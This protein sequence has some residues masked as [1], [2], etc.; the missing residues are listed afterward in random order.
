MAVREGLRPFG[1]STDFAHD[2]E[3][4]IKRARGNGHAAIVVDFEMPDAGGMAL[5]RLLR[6]QPEVYRTPIVVA[7][8]EPAPAKEGAA[9]LNVLKWIAKP[10]DAFALTQVLDGAIARGANGRPCILH[11]EDDHDILDLV[12]RALQPTVLVFAP[13]RSR[14][15][16]LRCSRI[17]LISWCSTSRLERHPASICCRIC[18]TAAAR[19]F[20]RYFLWRFRRNR[21]HSAGRGPLE[22]NRRFARRSGRRGSRSPHAEV[23]TATKGDGMNPT[24]ILHVDDEPDI[25]EIV[26]VSLSLNPDFQVRACA[27]GTDALAA[28][29]EW[30]PELILLDVMMP[31]MD[32]PA[33]LAQ[34]RKDPRTA[35]I[36][37][38]FMTARAQK[39]EVEQFIALGAQG[40]ISKPFDPMTLASEV[41]S[42]LHGLRQV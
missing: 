35:E 32:G 11:I 29:A 19:Q 14:R 9:E 27:S 13:I 39:R 36:P 17:T 18:A 15:L 31:K 8:A 38:L 5:I 34:L 3:D 25:R 33:T 20:R 30:S 12:A 37:V 42:H 1:F 4:A 16:A 7:S 26:D 6:E 40:V 10:I 23:R 22:Q 21:R 41:G 2:A 28:A 24:R